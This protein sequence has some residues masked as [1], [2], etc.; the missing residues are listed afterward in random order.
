V[1]RQDTH[2]GLRVDAEGQ[3]KVH[4]N[5]DAAPDHFL[6]LVRPCREGLV[7][8]AECMFAWYRLADL[9]AEQERFGADSTATALCL[10]VN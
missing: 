6:P 8:A 7:V 9:C 2:H 4:K 5:I 10:T 3:T 1:Q